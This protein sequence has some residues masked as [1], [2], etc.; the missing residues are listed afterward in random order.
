MFS[1]NAG[2]LVSITCLFFISVGSG[3]AAQTLFNYDDGSPCVLHEITAELEETVRSGSLCSGLP[4]LDSCLVGHWVMDQ[5]SY[6]HELRRMLEGKDG[7]TIQQADM[8][9]EMLI[10]DKGIVR[11]CLAGLVLGKVESRGVTGTIE[12]ITRGRSLVHIG[13]ETA[14]DFENT[15]CVNPIADEVTS[16]AK[17]TIGGH[18]SENISP[19]PA[20]FF[21]V[22]S[23]MTCRGNTL[24]VV[25]YP[26]G[27]D[28]VEHVFNRRR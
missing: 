8:A 22:G 19:P 27:V 1:L 23:K 17:V 21:P 10:N 24:T 16:L 11:S 5:D 15:I 7:I 18:T 4:E 26:E 6:D 14:L 12:L 28:Y 2:H 13:Q 25:T 3:S 20:L 9:A